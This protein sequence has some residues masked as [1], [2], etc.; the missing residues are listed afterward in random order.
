[1]VCLLLIVAMPPTQ[2]TSK[3]PITGEDLSL[4]DLIQL[5]SNKVA[6]L[7]PSQMT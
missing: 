5:K 4:D 2:E 3:H 6:A 7:M 1:M